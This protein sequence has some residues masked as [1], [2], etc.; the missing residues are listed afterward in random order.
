MA[1]R[2]GPY[3]VTCVLAVVGGVSTAVF[4][5][6]ARAFGG[7]FPDGT[8]VTEVCAWAASCED[9]CVVYDCNPESCSHQGANKVCIKCEAN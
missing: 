9:T 3:I 5:A 8:P 2:L 6:P 4:A 7:G 1:V